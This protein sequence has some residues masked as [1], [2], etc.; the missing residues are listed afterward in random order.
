MKRRR[1][2][3]LYLLCFAAMVPV[4]LSAAFLGGRLL[5][6]IVMIKSLES[7]KV[8]TLKLDPSQIRWYKKN[9]ELMIDG[10]MFDVKSMAQQNGYLVV[11]GLFDE[12][13]TE[14]NALLEKNHD[15]D[16]RNSKSQHAI[17][18]VCLGII[19][20]KSQTS[21]SMSA[22]AVKQQTYPLPAD[23]FQ[24]TDIAILPTSPPPES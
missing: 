3:A 12:M 16:N 14:M 4:F 5:I 6:R 13:E 1:T 20:V 2:I 15:P 11:T 7:E 23:Q 9:H 24:L 22:L 17:Y 21:W 8:I 19:A 18:Q 10:K